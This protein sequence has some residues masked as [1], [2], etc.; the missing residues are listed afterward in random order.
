MWHLR[1]CRVSAPLFPPLAVI[2]IKATGHTLLLDHWM[3]HDTLACTILRRRSATVRGV[4]PGIW[5]EDSRCYR[6][7]RGSESRPEF[8]SWLYAERA[9]FGRTGG[10]RLAA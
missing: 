4:W 9:C 3:P 6:Y 1:K 2:V 10:V 7:S 8:A 5:H